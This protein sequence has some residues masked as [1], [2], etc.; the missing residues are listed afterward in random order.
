MRSCAPSIFDV[1][2]KCGHA[3]GSV[4]QWWHRYA[5]SRAAWLLGHDMHRVRST[6]RASMCD[7]GFIDWET[8]NKYQ[9]SVCSNSA[10]INATQISWASIFSEDRTTSS[11]PRAP[12]QDHQDLPDHPRSPQIT[13]DQ[14][15]HPRSPKITQQHPRSPNINMTVINF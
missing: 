1:D 9:F 6:P 10:K 11:S 3:G 4:L 13:Q 15:D 5:P 7:L 12:N 14:A 8:G 2:R